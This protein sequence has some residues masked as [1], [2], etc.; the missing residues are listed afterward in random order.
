[1]I[2]EALVKHIARLARLDLS[3]NERVKI[4]RDL[5]SILD[6][7]T[8]LNEIDVKGVEPFCSAASLYSVMR[9]DDVVPESLRVIQEIRDQFPHREGAYLKVKEIL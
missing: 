2:D 1:M 9:D 8:H 7:I 4:Q 3:D 5:S 6:Y